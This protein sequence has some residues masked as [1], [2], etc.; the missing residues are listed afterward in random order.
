MCVYVQDVYKQAVAVNDQ[1]RNH[2]I[3]FSGAKMRLLKWREKKKHPNW[4]TEIPRPSLDRGKIV[5][6]TKTKVD[7]F[8]KNLVVIE[9][10]LDDSQIFLTLNNIVENIENEVREN[11]DE[12]G[13]LK[14]RIKALKVEN[15]SL[16]RDL[17][18]TQRKLVESEEQSVTL[19]VERD[20]LAFINTLL[21][22]EP[23][24]EDTSD[25]GESLDLSFIDE[26]VHPTLKVLFQI[27]HVS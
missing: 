19:E 12:I 7:F 2:P 11:E 8:E 10:G 26:K 9:R 5:D 21:Y 22:E 27:Y 14:E 17:S 23:C 15:N 25:E 20:H 16:R 3:M 18:M 24:L 4:K 13:S 1:L 6:E